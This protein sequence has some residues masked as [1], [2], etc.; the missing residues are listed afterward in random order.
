M[1]LV[2]GVDM[3]VVTRSEKLKLEGWDFLI[4]KRKLD[5]SVLDYLAYSI[6]G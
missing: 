3:F 5:S 2:A 1:I 4:M 6:A